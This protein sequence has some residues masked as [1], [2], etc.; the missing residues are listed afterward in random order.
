MQ[1]PPSR[2]V[3]IKSYSKNIQQIYRR[4]PMPKCDFNKVSIKNAFTD[5]KLLQMSLFIYEPENTNNT[6][7]PTMN[8]FTSTTHRTAH[9][10]PPS[11]FRPWS[12]KENLTFLAIKS[13]LI[14]L[15]LST[16]M[17]L[18][19]SWRRPFSYRNQPIDLV[20]LW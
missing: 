19:L 12:V 7:K 13:A 17:H 15:H 16:M 3:L 8:Y 11:K 2:G 1:K 14:K 5:C 4:T 9:H 20:S 10:L 18:T 6:G